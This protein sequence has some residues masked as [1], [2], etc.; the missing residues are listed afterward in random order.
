MQF[1]GIAAPAIARRLWHQPDGTFSSLTDR[2]RPKGVIAGIRST[3]S[4]CSTAIGSA[5]KPAHK[6]PEEVGTS[7]ALTS[8]DVN[9]I[10]MEVGLYDESGVPCSYPS[11]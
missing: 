3:V 1:S 4:T 6:S 10:L 2:P 9:G 11:I 8:T 7:T 5:G